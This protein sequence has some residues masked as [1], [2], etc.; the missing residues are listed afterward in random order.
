MEKIRC[1]N[2][3]KKFKPFRRS[4]KFCST[5]CR[6]SFGRK[7][8]EAKLLPTIQKVTHI[9]DE[10]GNKKPVDNNFFNALV[11]E[12]RKEKPDENKTFPFVQND[13]KENLKEKESKKPVNATITVTLKPKDA[14]PP[15]GLTKSQMLRWIR[16]N[17]K[18]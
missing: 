5:K 13:G 16:E 9:L 7:R 14:T 2:C 18:H 17:K 4:A 10:N 3:D 8:A 12:M 6:V 1:L 15:T 11:E